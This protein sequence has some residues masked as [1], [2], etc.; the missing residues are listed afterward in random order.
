[1]EGSQRPVRN[2]LKD[3]EDWLEPQARYV[4]L[5]GE[6]AVTAEECAQLGQ[7]IGLHVKRLGH[8]RALQSFRDTYPFSF[9]V[10]LVAQGIYG[11]QGGAYWSEV[12][13][14]TNLNRTYAWQV[15]QAFEDILSEM[16]L[17]LFYDMR[18]GAQRY[19]SLI[20][21]HGGIPNY[22]LPD[23]FRN[24]LQPSVVRSWYA[25]MSAAALIEDW[26]SR[27]QYFTDKPV[28][29][30]LVYGERVSEDFVERCREMARKYTNSD[31]LDADDLGL[32]E[33]VVAAYEQWIAEQSVD[34]FQRETGEQWRL[35]KPEIMIHPWIEGV[36]L[37][38]PP[39]QVP[40]TDVHASVAWR[41]KAGD[42]TL[43]VPVRVRRSGFDWKTTAES[44]PLRRPAETYEV[45]L[46]AN[47]QV[48]STWRHQGIDTERPLLV[49]DPD[50]NVLVKQA[51][52]LPA[53]P[54]GLL[55]PADHT[56]EIVGDAHLL[57][58][59][60]R[61]PWGWATFK[62]QVWDLTLARR[63]TLTQ[64]GYRRLEIMLRPDETRQ[65]PRLEGGELISPEKLGVR[66]P[67]YVGAP[68]RVRIPL[69]SRR[70]LEEE[71]VLWRTAIQSKWA[72]LPSV[73][74]TRTLA[75][76]RSQLIV[77]EGY[78]DLLL[79]D[80]GLLGETP[81]GNYVVRLRGPLGRDAE[82]TLRIV[83]QLTIVGHEDIYLPDP[84]SGP[85]PAMLLAETLAGD[86]IDCQVEMGECPVVL[87]EQRGDRWQY[88]LDA[89]P[90]VTDIE[91][92]VSR[93]LPDGDT[94]RV[95][96][97]VSVRRLRWALEGIQ[98][99]T[100][101]REWT[102][103]II[104]SS[105]DA[106]M[107]L[108]SPCLMVNLPLS[109]ACQVWLR[110]H[111]LDTD[112]TQLQATN[113][114]PLLPGQQI[115]RF[116][117]AAFTDTI[118]NS[119]SPVLRMELEIRG[120][121]GH[122]NVLRWPVLSLT[123]ALLVDDIRLTMLQIDD[124]PALQLQWREP[125]R[126][127]NRH[128][129]FWPLWQPWE[130]F[131]EMAIPDTAEGVFTFDAPVDRLPPSKY[132][133]E[134]LI[135]DPWVPAI[136]QQPQKGAPATAD[137]EM[138][139][140][141]VQW[142]N[143]EARLRRYGEHFALFLERVMLS[144][145]AE[146]VERARADWQWCFEHLDDGSVRQ[147]LLLLGLA[148]ALGDAA[149]S[150]ALQVKM[151]SAWR[152]ERLVTTLE[153]GEISSQEFQEYLACLPQLDLLP[154]KTC[155]YLLDVGNEVIRLKAAEALVSRSNP[156]GMEAL[157][158]WV[159]NARLSDADALGVL[160][161]NA[162]FSIPY[163]QERL[164]SPIAVRLLRAVS[165]DLGDNSPIVQIGTWIFCDAGWGRIERIEDQTGQAIGQFIR[166]QTDFRLYVTLRPRY[167]A[168][169]IVVDLT[170]GSISFPTAK[171]IYT[172]SWCRRFTA[173]DRDYSTLI[174]RHSAVVHWETDPNTPG[175]M[176][177]R[178]ER[179]T[180]RVLG[181]MQYRTK[182]PYDQLGILAG[183]D[184]T[185]RDR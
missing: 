150:K 8:H 160:K 41:V 28:M 139:S 55:Y 26:M 121:P 59:W 24:L 100:L 176:A 95:P 49:F 164:P 77:G 114:I 136:S 105:V 185:Q 44:L 72:A 84:Q 104:K 22:C 62:G 3:W 17:P 132:R 157:L 47:G 52:S 5:L 120:L 135:V 50:R 115:L 13:Q 96:I 174:G 35:R 165:R 6:I 166:G 36:L 112:G 82:F 167:D 43:T 141:E 178:K 63:F 67:V 106:L 23:F 108:Q 140:P 89:D 29:R 19:V 48:K 37:D 80:R 110:L 124:R 173:Q 51:Y 14:A 126:L 111:L 128:V 98:A 40:A 117:L 156:R 79:S 71:L 92:T 99:E 142:Q 127:R 78:V 69:T 83:P 116:D 87:T 88:R 154:Q 144:L 65:R 134:L 183:S 60:P 182:S 145:D 151:F 118:R 2:N 32:P 109:D 42:D 168:R 18:E 56:L 159:E 66:A 10:Y 102:G 170:T 103:S 101:Q 38:L 180:T 146:N 137:I 161:C 39:Q 155:E 93:P 45:S 133:V 30:F 90:A 125:V 34:Q 181:T 147:V 179:T 175:R 31:T 11:Y 9:A 91:L 86:R 27:K 184:L 1:M 81:F 61:L 130:S 172:C 138:L 169:Q 21:A 58:E 171:C 70:E 113:S 68:P 33:R 4:E 149:G 75:D 177:F 7:A 97:V 76:L 162:Q 123:Q 153:R 16:S 129:R 85:P 131:T 152:V 163:L 158:R 148:K 64:D 53:R 20:L 46:M 122:E 15:G 57:E 25:S 73:E 143:L 74:I 94:V 119:D 54:L 12:I 107:Q